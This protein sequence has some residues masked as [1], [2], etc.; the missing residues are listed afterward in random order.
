M[1][2]VCFVYNVSGSRDSDDSSKSSSSSP[3]LY[4]QQIP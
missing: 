2:F 1:K 3:G 4:S